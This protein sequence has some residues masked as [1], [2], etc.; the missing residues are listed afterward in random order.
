[1]HNILKLSFYF[2]MCFFAF[3]ANAQINTSPIRLA[4]SS[5]S[6]VPPDGFTYFGIAN[7][8]GNEDTGSLIQVH[9]EPVESY[10]IWQQRFKDKKS[11]RHYSK[12]NGTKF[13]D[14]FNITVDGQTVPVMVSYRDGRGRKGR[15]YRALFKAKNSILISA[16]IMDGDRTSRKDVTAAFQ[17][18]KINVTD[19]FGVF[20]ETN[21]T[22]NI[23]PPFDYIT[24]TSDS[25]FLKTYAEI[26]YSYSK[27]SIGI[28][29]DEIFIFDGEPKIDTLGQAAAY[30]FPTMSEFY[31]EENPNKSKIKFSNYGEVETG[32]GKA[33]RI[34]SYY[35]N[36]MGIQYIWKMEDGQYMFL[37]ALG[38]KKDLQDLEDE[39]R[40]IAASLQ[41]KNNE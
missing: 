26:D 40:S 41:L 5:V 35:K 1:M 37:F 2:C 11:A 14:L 19:I 16:T 23:I 32:P 30:F 4:K 38:N 28:G 13:E 21:F 12:V 22:V 27:P 29:F 15:H 8:V 6:M 10:K 25:A 39:V 7:G 31:G 34:V 24:T 20:D 33:F 3:T 17:S 36:R 18:V 9:E